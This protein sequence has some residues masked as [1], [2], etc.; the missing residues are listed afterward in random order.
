MVEAQDALSNGATEIDTVINIGA[1]KSGNYNRIKDEL[2]A[3]KNIVRHNILKVILEV[4]LL[5]EEEVK[6]ACEICIEAKVDFVKT[7]TGFNHIHTEQET[8]EHA[9][10]LL[11]Y[12]EGAPIKVK[13][14]SFIRTL[15]GVQEL[16]R[17]GVARI[18]CSKGVMI[19]NDLQATKIKGEPK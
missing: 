11:K 17:L 19:I 13:A 5:T 9:K 7:S 4:G 1:L 14:S 15:D 6:K 8:I 2:I 18:G 10:L 3:L 16:I 12:T